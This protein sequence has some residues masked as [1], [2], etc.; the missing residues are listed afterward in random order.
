M[1]KGKQ[2]SESYVGQSAR[3]KE[4]R[5]PLV[6]KAKYTNDYT[7]EGQLYAYILRSPHAAAKI[8]SVDLSGAKKISRVHLALC[9]RDIL[10]TPMGS[11]II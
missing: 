7:F 11:R 3:A 1:V 2:I 4:L 10:S 9:G 8:N 6:G 5:A